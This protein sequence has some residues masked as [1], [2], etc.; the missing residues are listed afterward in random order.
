M[1]VI[2]GI[3]GSKHIEM[4]L[5]IRADGRVGV[6]VDRQGRGC[7]WNEKMKYSAAHGGELREARD[8]L[9][10]DEMKPPLPGRKY[11]LFLYT[12]HS[13]G[14]SGGDSVVM[15][16]LISHL[17]TADDANSGSDIE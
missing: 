17:S 16:Y 4:A 10:C 7:V 1:R 13:E 8:D 6:L 3:L 9:G 2:R 14:S 12:G 5:Q 15:Y 11:D